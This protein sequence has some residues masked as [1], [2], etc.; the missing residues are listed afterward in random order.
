ML[1]IVACGQP[2]PG[3]EIRIVDEAGHEL[4]ERREGRLEFHGPS[5]T[6]GYFHNEAKTRELA[7]T[8]F[9]GLRPRR[10][11]RV[12]SNPRNSGGLVRRSGVCEPN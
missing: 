4:G 9:A 3:H 2:L 7:E 10:G 1:E 6:R 8:G 5:T 12:Y 11:F